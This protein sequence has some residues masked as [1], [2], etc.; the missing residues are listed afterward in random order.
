MLRA[1]VE[2]RTQHRKN[3]E[4]PDTYFAVQC[5][6]E[7]VEPLRTLNRDVA[8]RRGITIIYCG[9]G[10]SQRQQTSRSMFNQAKQLANEVAH[11]VN[12]GQEYP[13][14]EN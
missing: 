13:K 14:E 5:V 12:S 1:F 8:K 9:Q 7:G 3:G 10:Y 2:K 11:A 4:G 6:P